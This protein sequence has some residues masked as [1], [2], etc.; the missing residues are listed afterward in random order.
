MLSTLARYT[1]PFVAWLPAIAVAL[2]ACGGD[3]PTPTPTAAPAATTTRPPAAAASSVASPRASPRASPA[4]GGPAIEL[5]RANVP[6][7]ASGATV[8]QPAAGDREPIQIRVTGL[9]AGATYRLVTRY[10][11]GREDSVEFPA[12]VGV[13]GPGFSDTY[14]V[15]PGVPTGTYTIE[16]RT[17]DGASV[18]A[19]ATFT[20]TPR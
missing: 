1:R 13:F 17:R 9:E 4:A 15:E 5:L 6:L 7:P 10:P 11:D 12:T 14:T 16:L 20:V 2:V 19:T 8:P 3:A 18:L